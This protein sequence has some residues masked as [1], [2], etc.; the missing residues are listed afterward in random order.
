MKIKIVKNILAFLGFM[1]NMWCIVALPHMVK[2]LMSIYVLYLVAIWLGHN[3]DE[4][5]TR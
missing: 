5:T 4:D 1:F 2:W 3:D